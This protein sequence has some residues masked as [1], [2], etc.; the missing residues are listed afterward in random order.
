MRAVIQRVSGASVTVDGIVLARIGRGLLV[1]VGVQEG[2]GERDVEFLQRKITSLRIFEDEAGKMNLSVADLG[3][4]ILLVPQFTLF[5]DCRKGNR[6]SFIR[7]AAPE[8]GQRWYEELLQRL[9]AGG[10]AVE[11][12]RFQAHMQVQLVNDGPVTLIVDSRKE[13]Y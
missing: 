4:E 9:R 3:G 5:G 10:L 7:A 6:P 12:G 11:T 8:V 1:L 13:V 2:D